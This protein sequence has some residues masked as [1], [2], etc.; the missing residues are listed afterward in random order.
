[1]FPFE[2]PARRP[3]LVHRDG[4]TRS[5][6]ACRTAGDGPKGRCIS[7][8][9]D[10]RTNDLLDRA[11][12]KDREPCGIIQGSDRDLLRSS[13][14]LGKPRWRGGNEQRLSV[15]QAKDPVIVAQAGMG[16]DQGVRSAKVVRR[17]PQQRG[18]ILGN[19]TSRWWSKRI[20]LMESSGR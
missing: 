4:V 20:H 1:M 15:A 19:C 2:R 5:E 12:T 3:E 9:K 16:D 14:H 13:R 10:R 8:R 17:A 18:P 6:Q 11:T 7:V